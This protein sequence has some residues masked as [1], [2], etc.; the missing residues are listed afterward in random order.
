M[1]VAEVQRFALFRAGARKARTVLG[2]VLGKHDLRLVF[3][4][5]AHHRR[6]LA[7]L[8]RLG[9]VAL[10]YTDASSFALMEEL[11]LTTA[12]GFD[13]DFRLAGFRLVA[14]EGW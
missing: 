4:G 10:S 12:L 5:E 6:A 9:D 13:N 1:V 11:G 8:H 14:D 3:A 7:W 2:H